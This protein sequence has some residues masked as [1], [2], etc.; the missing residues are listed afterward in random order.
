MTIIDELL[1]LQDDGESR[2]LN[3]CVSALGNKTKQTVSST[4]GRLVGKKYI[5]VSTK[6]KEKIFTITSL[7]QEVITNTLDQIDLMDE[8]NWNEKWLFIIFNVPEKQR[9]YRDML[10]NRLTIMGFGRIQNSLWINGRDVSAKLKDILLNNALNKYIT[11]IKPKLS[12]DDIAEVAKNID[13]DWKN[14]RK[15]YEQFINQAET[16]LKSDKKSLFARFLVYHYSKICQEDP[17]IPLQYCPVSK[18]KRK[19]TILYNKVRKYC[20]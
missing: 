3:E 19:A 16:F 13:V 14:L 1:I 7:G 17:K 8:S 2:T 5:S 18:E 11:I 10:R 4:L 15:Q 9:K 20:Y 6:N 12:N